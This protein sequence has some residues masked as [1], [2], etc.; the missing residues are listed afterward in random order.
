[1]Q[2]LA[3][4]M[5]LQHGHL[6][7]KMYAKMKELGPI[8]GRVLGTPPLDPPMLSQQEVNAICNEDIT[9]D[10]IVEHSNDQSYNFNLNVHVENDDLQGR[11][12][13]TSSSDDNSER[14]EDTEP[15]KLSREDL[16]EKQCQ[17]LD[18]FQNKDMLCRLIKNLDEV[19]LTENFLHVIDV[20]S[21]GEMENEH[22]P[23]I[24]VMEVAKYL[25]CTT[26][27][28]MRFH[29]KSKAFWR[30]GYR[31]WHG[32]GLLLMSGSKNRGEVRNNETV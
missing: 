7:V 21:T 24:L 9:Y 23:L 4:G 32:K 17:L 14:G 29:D 19:S 30:V 6:S 31:K 20:L 15:Q 2:S 1:M 12:Y 28:L 5:D 8:G 3:G 27:T 13:S 16:N 11:D 26:T 25:R 10:G 22:L 18:K